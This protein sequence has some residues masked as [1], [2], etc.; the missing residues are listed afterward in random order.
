MNKK[1]ILLGMATVWL[2]GCASYL[3]TPQELRAA[4]QRPATGAL[5]T[6]HEPY[7]FDP[8]EIDEAALP[9]M[10]DLPVPP[11]AR[12]QGWPR[13]YTGIIKN[14]TWN[15]VSVPSGN[16]DATLIIPARSWI[17]YDTWL[18]YFDLTAYY[19]GKPYYC[20]KITADPRSVP[21]MCARYDFMVEIVK[22]EGPA[23][24]GKYGK[25]M[26]RRIRKK[27]KPAEETG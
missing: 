11:N 24:G 15:D 7:V 14:T 5:I 1:L 13:K 8:F 19:E 21:F 23:P 17:E 2:I 6:A 12:R 25:K 22:P 10:R 4:A 26:K 27:V 16:S 3:E 18:R 9:K 20:M